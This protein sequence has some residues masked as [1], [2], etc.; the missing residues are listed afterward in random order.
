MARAVVFAQRM[1]MRGNQV[2]ARQHERVNRLALSILLNLLQS[3]PVDTGEAIS[4]WILSLGHATNENIGPYAPGQYGSTRQ[5]NIGQ[6]YNVAMIGISD[7]RLEQPIYISNSAPHIG[8]LNNGWS[9]Q[10]PAG[11][12]QSSV[13]SA[14]RSARGFKVLTP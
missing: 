6:T 7:R 5:M 14:V 12:F 2:V 9:A 3:T 11:F 8:R 10:A 13:L 4:N 1:R